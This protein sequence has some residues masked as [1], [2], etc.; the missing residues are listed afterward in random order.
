M[1]NPPGR[2]RW[3][4]S[5]PPS[6]SIWRRAIKEKRLRFNAVIVALAAS[7]AVELIDFAAMLDQDS[8]VRLVSEGVYLT[9][10]GNRLLADAFL[11]VLLPSISGDE[12][13]VCC[14]DSLTERRR[15]Y[16]VRR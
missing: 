15:R 11:R 2:R 14:G 1:Y 7:I 5:P 16:D 10:N 12:T 3:R 8:T 6:D 13:I 4:V 9:T